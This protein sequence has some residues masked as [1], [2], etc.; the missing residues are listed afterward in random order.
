[1]AYT[2][3]T[4]IIPE[5]TVPDVTTSTP[6]GF[7]PSDE[8]KRDI[9]TVEKLFEKSKKHR[10]TYDEKWLEYYKFFRGRQWTESRPAYRHSEVINMGAIAIESTTSRPVA[11]ACVAASA[12]KCK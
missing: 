5:H 10:S 1:M 7:K 3:G 2:E 4:G 8:E 12:V 9:K 11:I 6:D